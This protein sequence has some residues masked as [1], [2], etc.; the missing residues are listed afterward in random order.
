M[1]DLD[2]GENNRYSDGKIYRIYSPS[3]PEAGV[4]I[5][6]SINTLKKRL[7][8]HKSD[9]KR[10][11]RGE[12]RY[13]SSFKIMQYTDAKIKVVELYPCQNKLELH[14]RE[15][16]WIKNKH[17][18]NKQQA[19]RTSRQYREDN[20]EQITQQKQLYYEK[21][22]KEINVK[23]SEKF[24]CPCGGQFTKT[25]KSQHSKSSK[26]QK[27]TDVLEESESEE[28]SGSESNS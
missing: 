1:S 22:K 12:F 24:E 13:V 28:S 2:I 10:Y 11:L 23:R 27:Y 26:H 25:N 7:S 6:S 21:N 19:G 18:I 17:A 5:G 8:G 9:Y 20:V 15:G 14:Q 4:Y 16:Y 3:L